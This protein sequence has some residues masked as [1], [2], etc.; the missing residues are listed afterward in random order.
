M[1]V[2]LQ[3]TQSLNDQNPNQIIRQS[4]TEQRK[5]ERQWQQ[6]MW[7]ESGMLRRHSEPPDITVGL[8]NSSRAEKGHK[9]ILYTNLLLN[10]MYH[11][12]MIF[13]KRFQ[14]GS[15]IWPLPVESLT[16]YELWCP[17]FSPLG[18]Q[19]ELH[20]K[21][22]AVF[23]FSWVQSEISGALLIMLGRQRL[24]Q[25]HVYTNRHRKT[26]THTN[27]VVYSSIYTT[28]TYKGIL[29]YTNTQLTI[30]TL[31]HSW[32]THTHTHTHTHTYTH[33]HH[34]PHKD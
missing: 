15:V 21:W 1:Q 20:T 12:P 11:I 3:A 31:S 25:L 9:K 7:K 29:H 22:T 14:C 6:A 10:S 30:N 4:F 32:Y 34:I 13:S 27:K 8:H 16:L 33:T 17:F 24:T 19:V 2:Q 5:L 18:S 23:D 28:N 26:Y